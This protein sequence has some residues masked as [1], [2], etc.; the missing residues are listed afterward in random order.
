MN[1]VMAFTFNRAPNSGGLR[2][3]VRLVAPILLGT[4]ALT[5]CAS[6]TGYDSAF[7]AKT[8]FARR[9]LEFTPDDN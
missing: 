6:Q 2:F 3:G 8:T 4:G 9:Q 5:G 7:S 1:S